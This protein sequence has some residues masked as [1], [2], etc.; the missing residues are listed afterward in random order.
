MQKPSRT[1]QTLRIVDYSSAIYTWRFATVSQKLYRL[2]QLLVSCPGGFK[3]RTSTAYDTESVRCEVKFSMSTLWLMP[4]TCITH[5]R[6]RE[7]L[8]VESSLLEYDAVSISKYFRIRG[9]RCLHLQGSP[10][11]LD[12]SSEHLITSDLAYRMLVRIIRNMAMN[13]GSLRGGTYFTS[14]VSALHEK[15]KC[16]VNQSIRF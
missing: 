7:D 1:T 2:G 14:C 15:L 11:R 10:R 4:E 16:G 13:L 12:F 8:Q 6:E 9:D 3:I 5:G